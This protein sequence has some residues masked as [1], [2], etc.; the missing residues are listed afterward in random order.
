MPNYEWLLVSG[1]FNRFETEYED[2][3]FKIKSTG[4]SGSLLAELTRNFSLN[5]SVVF[6]RAGSDSDFVKTDNLAHAVYLTY[7]R[8]GTYGLTAGYQND[9]NDD[10]EDAIKGNSFYLTGW[11]MP[12]ENFEFKGD[13]GSRV[14]NVDDGARLVGDQSRNRF[15][16]YGKYKAAGK[17]TFKA[18]VKSKNRKNDQLASEIEYTSVYFETF[19][20]ALEYADISAGYSYAAGDY[21]NLEQAFEF[22]SHQAHCDI[23]TAEYKNFAGQ[24][25]IVYYR[26]QRDLDVESFNIHFRVSYSFKDD[27]RIEAGYKVY[28]F[29]DLNFLDQYYT[30][31]IVEIN[32]IKSFKF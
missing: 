18:G 24:F 29:D 27:N 26:S 30:E 4:V 6:N 20:S 1:V 32:I 11:Y 31:N 3:G 14:E 21:E 23:R 25:G 9:I 22:T 7:T 2:T 13:Y 19:Y 10:Y 8:P 12:N 28:N 17:G 15:K 16:F 5:Y